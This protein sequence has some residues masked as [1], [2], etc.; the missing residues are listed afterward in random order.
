MVFLPKATIYAVIGLFFPQPLFDLEN[1]V[2]LAM[3]T[4]SHSFYIVL[5][6]FSYTF[7]EVPHVLFI[8]YVRMHLF[9]YYFSL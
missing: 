1:P 5:V 7:R 6:T 8:T 9:V 4:S 2:F 3:Y